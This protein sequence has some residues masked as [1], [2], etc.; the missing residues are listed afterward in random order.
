MTE[1]IGL[2][3]VFE[4]KDFQK[5]L[6][7]YLKGL[8]DAEKAT[9]STAGTSGAG[10][11]STVAGGLGSATSGVGGLTSVLG[12]A[13]GGLSLFATA[14]LAAAAAIGVVLVKGVMEGTRAI[15][16][17]G[18]DAIAT[19]GRVNE[20]TTIAQLLGQRAGFTA[21]AI[22][23]E[24]AKVKEFG[25]QADIAAT[26]V[27]QFTRYN[28]DLADASKIARVAQDAAQVSGQNSSETLDQLLYGILTYNKRVLRTAGLN[29]DLAG[30]MGEYAKSIGKVS[31]A[32][33]EEEQVQAAL[34]AT[35]KEG[36]KIRG[37]Y[38]TLQATSPGKQLRSLER[39]VFDLKDAFG[40][41]FQ[42]AFLSIV[43][44]ARNITQAFTKALSPA[45]ELGEAFGETEQEGG[46]LYGIMVKLGAVAAVV[47]DAF[48]WAAET[49]S[50]WAINVLGDAEA[51][52]TD[53]AIRA[54][55]WGLNIAIQLADGLISGAIGALTWAMNQITALLT[56]W[57]APGSA[58]KVAPDLPKWGAA[59]M[60]EYLKGFTQ[61]DFSALKAIQAPLQ[62]A[63]ALMVTT[64]QIGK[65]AGGK[66]LAS[67]STE[68]AKVLSG[69]GEL[70]P[71]VFAKLTKA[72]GP[73]GT[74]IADLTGKV[75]ELA[76]AEEK[77]ANARKKEDEATSNVRSAIADY[78][79]ALRS[80]ATEEAL[81]GQLEYINAQEAQRQA[82]ITERSE[83]EKTMDV[84]REAVSLQTQ[85]VD[86]LLMLT[87]AQLVMPDISG[88]LGGA[89]GGLGGALSSALDGAF[90]GFTNKINEAVLEMKQKIL[91]AFE[92]LKTAWEDK[93]SPMFEEF[94]K[95]WDLFEIRVLTVWYRLFGPERGIVTGLIKDLD[96][97]P[98]SEA[99]GVLGDSLG[100]L[101]DSLAGLVGIDLS[102]Q[103]GFLDKFALWAKDPGT[104]NKFQTA[105][106]GLAGAIEW[107]AGA[108]DWLAEAIGK[109]RNIGINLGGLMVDPEKLE[110]AEQGAIDLF[111]WGNLEIEAETV[112]AGVADAL[113][114]GAESKMPVLAGTDFFGNLIDTAITDITT[115]FNNLAKSP[116]EFSALYGA[117][118][119][120]VEKEEGWRIHLTTTVA[121]G[122]LEF[123]A[124]AV[125]P[126][127][128]S[129]GTEGDTQKNITTLQEDSMG[130]LATAF[131]MTGGL[132][133]SITTFKD[134][135]LA[136]LVEGVGLVISSFDL[137]ILKIGDLQKAISKVD[138]SKLDPVLPD[139]PP[140]LAVGAELSSL[141]MATLADF[142]LKL[143][144]ASTNMSLPGFET[145]ATTMSTMPAPAMASMTMQTAAQ[146]RNI[147]LSFSAEINT[148][149]DMTI[150]EDRVSR[151]VIKLLT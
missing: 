5:G 122:I 90:A 151:I 77:L 37:I 131:G 140:P 23:D 145:G 129:L 70:D 30:G 75:L 4:T 121:E 102:K 50:N 63:I 136:S 97:T 58:P 89:A 139:S 119:E 7:I 67:L 79:R 57:L 133:Q 61:A 123:I 44:S 16:G 66:L 147:N 110:R 59:A 72:A 54:F 99:F 100:D 113:V 108:I 60:T 41:P 29:V 3:S 80:G 128:V 84:M 51:T 8:K 95:A 146:V 86:Q 26:T 19:A 14:G 34:Q 135:L 118:D 137:L 117:I 94:G 141:S 25:I 35:L 49:L 33:T 20:L 88:A 85:L 104:I 127:A 106:E 134:D 21:D 2:E 142:V 124:N 107:L 92:P 68:L 101:V 24:I 74:E 76:V 111:G 150:F 42:D 22:S 103:E 109:I 55:D 48:K 78:N 82:A 64:G 105:I 93:W 1:K 6:D 143:G 53:F 69:Q 91:D 31:A 13:T 132:W 17:F 32:L 45:K 36:I 38:E 11:L 120:Q 40:Q 130:G 149:M 12:G 71:S 62:K 47:A 43:A 56:A 138:W 125:D 148:D 114:R 116:E 65:I 18:K 46:Q 98:I 73:F 28:L 83:L 87:Q 39:D 9:T 10:G 96:F 81:D 15:V 52:M 126:L 27:A 144:K 112:G 115:F